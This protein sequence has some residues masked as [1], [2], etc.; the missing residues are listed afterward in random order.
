MLPYQWQKLIVKELFVEFNFTIESLKN[1]KIRRIF[2][3]I[4]QSW[5]KIAEH[6][7]I[8]FYK[9]ERNVKFNFRFGVVINSHVSLKK[10]KH[11]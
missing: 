9:V 1:H 8:G 3:A 10:V 6:T 11:F 4:Q 7:V 5:K 2:F